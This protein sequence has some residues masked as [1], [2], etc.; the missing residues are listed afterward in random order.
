MNESAQCVAARPLSPTDRALADLDT[1][2]GELNVEISNA[3]SNMEPVL[4]PAPPS[5]NIKTSLGPI[6]C[7]S[8]MVESINRMTGLVAR[9]RERLADAVS[10]LEI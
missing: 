2:L 8:P 3:I 1:Q 10:R 6:E 7:Q 5:E 9:M 4:R